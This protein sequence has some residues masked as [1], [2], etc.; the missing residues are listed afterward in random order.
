MGAALMD[1]GGALAILDASRE[2]A[3]AALGDDFIV[4]LDPATSGED[5]TLLPLT[6]VCAVGARLDDGG[7]SWA[8]SCGGRAYIDFI[9]VDAETMTAA[10]IN[11]AGLWCIYLPPWSFDAAARFASVIIADRGGVSLGADAAMWQRRALAV[12]KAA[13]GDVNGAAE[14]LVDAERMDDA[15]CRHCGVVDCAGECV[16]L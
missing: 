7:W 16:M 11:A 13:S 2:W 15:N 1:N 14:M 6:Q 12:M 9:G 8:F 10:E 3:L 5:N 4:A